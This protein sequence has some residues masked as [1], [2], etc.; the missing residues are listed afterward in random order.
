[1]GEREI[2]SL[3]QLIVVPGTLRPQWVTELQTLFRPKSIDI[4]LYDSPK[5]GNAAF[6]APGG[7][8]QSSIHEPHNRIIVTTHSAR[9][10][11]SS[12]ERLP[13]FSPNSPY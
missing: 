10:P 6:W 11:P 5:A 1:M 7:P 8:L 3:P 12:L 9:S 13:D 4:L 2:E